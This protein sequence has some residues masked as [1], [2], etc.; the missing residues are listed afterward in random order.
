M[1]YKIRKIKDLTDYENDRRRKEKRREVRKKQRIKYISFYIF[2]WPNV[3]YKILIH[4]V[5]LSFLT[6]LSIFVSTWMVS[7]VIRQ[8]VLVALI[9]SSPFIVI[10]VVFFLKEII[11]NN[12]RLFK[13]FD[14]LTDLY[15]QCI[16]KDTGL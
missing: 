1:S 2:G 16:K 5:V 10:V 9:A 4:P 11:Y 15:H 7:Y 12:L 3:L 13:W 6:V 8:W 14:K